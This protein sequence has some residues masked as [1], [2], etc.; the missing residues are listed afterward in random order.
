MRS[1][2]LSLSSL[3]LSKPISLKSVKSSSFDWNL[4]IGWKQAKVAQNR[5]LFLNIHKLFTNVVCTT[6]RKASNL[7]WFDAC[8]ING[9]PDRI[10]TCDTWRRRP[11]LHPAELQTLILLVN[12]FIISQQKQKSKWIF[13]C[14]TITSIL[15]FIAFFPTPRYNKDTAIFSPSIQG[16]HACTGKTS[17]GTLLPIFLTNGRPPI[18]GGRDAPLLSKSR[19]C[20]LRAKIYRKMRRFPYV[21]H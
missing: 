14:F 7:T 8:S 21:H 17:W 5:Q 20:N 16:K 15:L 3:A 19:P 2:W 6:S 12:R 13:Y 11:V 10:R 18:W 4:G 1:R 9:A